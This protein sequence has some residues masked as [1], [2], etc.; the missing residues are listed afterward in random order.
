M[1]R[2]VLDAWDRLPT[3]LRDGIRAGWGGFAV[4]TGR[5]RLLPNFIIIGTQ[6]GG[7]TS[8]YRSLVRHPDVRP[9][10]TKELRY[11]D[12]HYARGP[13][14]YRSRFPSAWNLAMVRRIRGT[15]F[16]TGESSP[17]YLFHPLVPARVKETA[18]DVKLIV[19]LRNPV[20][21]AYSHYWHQVHRG[22]ETLPFEEAV[23]R[24]PERL[25][26]ALERVVGDHAEPSFALHH[27]SY[28]ARGVYADQLE[29]WLTPFARDRLLIVRS[30]DLFSAPGPT[31]RGVTTFLGLRPW[32]PRQYE[33][34]NAFTEGPMPDRVRAR[35]VEHFRPH[36]E[37]LRS[38][39]GRDFGWDE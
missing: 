10:I 32:E 34:T 12:L 38:L 13:T 2:V 14:W 16:L 3:P 22:F 7:T 39:L 33:A 25:E 31:F 9:A 35:L 21:R 6:R 29:R 5:A 24:E 19:L 8:L 26:G 17:D 30:E 28:L 1:S 18:P 15:G 23:A 20:D 36:N 27:H 4:L 11:F 37:R